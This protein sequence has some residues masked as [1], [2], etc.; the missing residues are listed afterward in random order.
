MTKHQLA[1]RVSAAIV[2]NMVA[3]CTCGLGFWGEDI[4]QAD[5]RLE[6]HIQSVTARKQ[7]LGD[8]LAAMAR[9]EESDSETKAGLIGEAIGILLRRE[10]ER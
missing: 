10:R 3:F 1:G 5:T 2:P 9:T 8:L 6:G 4:T 7:Q